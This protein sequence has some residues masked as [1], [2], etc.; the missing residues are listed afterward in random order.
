MSLRL[1]GD[2]APGFFAVRAAFETNF[3]KRGEVGAAVCVYRHG[4][5]VVDL[6]GGMARA[7]GHAPWHEDTIVCMM[8]VGKSLTALCALMLVDR[9]LLELDAAVAR[10]WPAFG[11]NGKA[12]I[13]VRMLLGGLS[14]VLYADA[15]PDGAGLHWATMIQAFEVQ[16]P[17]WPVRGG[18]AYHSMSFG[19]LVG[20]LVRRVD[21]RSIDQFFAEEVAIPLRVDY[22][23]GLDDAQIARSADIIPN[24]ASNTHALMADPTSKFGRAWRILPDLQVRANAED[25]RRGLFPSANGHGNA[26][27][28]ARIFAALGAGGRLD[29]VQLLSAGLIEQLCIEMWDGTCAMTGRHYRYGLGFFLNGSPLVP[30]GSSRTAFGHPGVGGA[31]AFAD[32]ENGIS[33][34]YSPN[35]MCEGAGVGSRCEALVTALYQ[36]IDPPMR[37]SSVLF[38]S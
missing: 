5:L 32:P 22:G 27:A 8:S 14:G 25:F 31:L 17:E 36:L 26:R 1:G 21:G 15:A 33:F 28:V 38:E 24:S 3:H 10:Y 4:A 19:Y 34:S 12:M 16:A 2:V 18:H 20:E 35:S 23:F 13:T 6:W 11:Q 29:G 7:D 9:G 30:M 37:P